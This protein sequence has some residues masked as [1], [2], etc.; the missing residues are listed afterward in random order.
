MR[1]IS[2]SAKGSILPRSSGNGSS[3]D[4]LSGISLSGDALSDGALAG[5]VLSEDALAGGVLSDGAPSDCARAVPPSD[6]II[7]PTVMTRISP[8]V[9]SRR[10][11]C[12]ELR[13]V[14]IKIPSLVD[15]RLIADPTPDVASARP[16][17][18][19]NLPRIERTFPSSSVS[20][21]HAV[22][23]KRFDSLQHATGESGLRRNAQQ[24]PCIVLSLAPLL[25]S[26]AVSGERLQHRRI[27]RVEAMS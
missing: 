18:M 25:A 22:G 12:V 23:S 9:R 4:S 7:G 13:I 15:V 26:H 11:D 8:A 10:A 2:S 19:S 1:P 17:L 27:A 6:P 14:R 3:D 5:G 24:T 20:L 16:P 21:D